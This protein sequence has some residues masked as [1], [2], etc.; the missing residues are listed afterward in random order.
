MKARPIIENLFSNTL[1]EEDGELLER[2]FSKEEIKEAVFR[3]AKDKSP[4]LDGFT[5]LFYQEC[6]T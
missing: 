6:W 2:V 1:K 3:M 5:L 4:G